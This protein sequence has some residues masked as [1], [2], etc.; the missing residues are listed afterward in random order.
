MD[1]SLWI[2]VAVGA[3]TLLGFA[4][5]GLRTI[6]RGLRVLLELTETIHERSE[7]L[8]PHGGRSVRDRVVAIDVWRRG[9]DSTLQDYE[10]RLRNL[11]KHPRRGPRRPTE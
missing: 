4:G 6:F 9:V 1:I 3:A 11:E 8:A 7:E 2:T 5:R 10:G